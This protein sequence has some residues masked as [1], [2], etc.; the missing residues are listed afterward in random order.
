MSHTMIAKNN[1]NLY[2]VCDQKYDELGQPAEN[3]EFLLIKEQ[4]N[5]TRRFQAF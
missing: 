1:G 4:L 2:A 3:S 5:I